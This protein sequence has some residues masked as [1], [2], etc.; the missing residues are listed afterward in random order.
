M[1]FLSRLWKRAPNP[2]VPIDAT[3]VARTMLGVITRD[4]L[5]TANLLREQDINIS[6][7]QSER[8][9]T[10]L[11]LYH[12][13]LFSVQFVFRLPSQQEVNAVGATVLKACQEQMRS[14]KMPIGESLLR[15]SFRETCATGVDYYGRNMITDGDRAT[16]AA[17]RRM[18][19]F[20]DV[21]ERSPIAMESRLLARVCHVVGVEL[22]NLIVLPLHVHYA[23]TIISMNDDLKRLDTA[24][25]F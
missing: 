13:T 25:A 23:Q 10:E 24:A 12:F 7:A 5:V 9:F 19:R 4:L 1:G 3:K 11:F 14:M 17:V 8:L 16:I 6:D 2:T 18:C 22:P 21:D 15:D 20:K